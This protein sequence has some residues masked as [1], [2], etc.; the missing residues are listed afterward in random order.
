MNDYP[1]DPFADDFGSA[2]FE[3]HVICRETRAKWIDESGG[4]AGGE[5]PEVRAGSD[6]E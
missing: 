4:P 1:P 5:N 3:R 6:D 2:S